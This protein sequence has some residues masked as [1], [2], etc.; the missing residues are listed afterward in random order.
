VLPE[1][2]NSLVNVAHVSG[3]VVTRMRSVSLLVIGEIAYT[4]QWYRYQFCCRSS[5]YGLGLPSVNSRVLNLNAPAAEVEAAKLHL[6]RIPLLS[7]TRLRRGWKIVGRKQNFQPRQ[8]ARA[9]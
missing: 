2:S 4:C 5:K 6:R 9:L 3:Y 8:A 7:D 1:N